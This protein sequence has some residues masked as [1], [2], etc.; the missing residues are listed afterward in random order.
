MTQGSSNGIESR[1]NRK[2]KRLDR[3]R[4][5]SRSDIPP[6]LTVE[7]ENEISVDLSPRS[8]QAASL[9]FGSKTPTNRDDM[10]CRDVREL[11]LRKGEPPD[12]KEDR[13]D[14]KS[15]KGKWGETGQNRANGAK[16]WPRETGGRCDDLARQGVW[17]SRIPI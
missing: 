8:G 3:V 16:A 6:R 17:V 11:E 1:L 2:Q 10:T 15:D 7:E 13:K 9:A 12:P 4:P 5:W 14:E